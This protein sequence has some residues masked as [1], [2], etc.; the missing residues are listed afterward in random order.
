MHQC[1]EGESLSSTALV[2]HCLCK[3]SCFEET[4]IPNR[5]NSLALTQSRDTAESHGK[6]CGI[7]LRLLPTVI[8]TNVKLATSKRSHVTRI[9]AHGTGYFRG[10]GRVANSLAWAQLSEEKPVKICCPNGS[11][12]FT[13]GHRAGSW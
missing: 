10:W 7:T 9:K 12:H 4:C 6:P 2:C 5:V 11:Y 1:R 13:I 8:N 3:K